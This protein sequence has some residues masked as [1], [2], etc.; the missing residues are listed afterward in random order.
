MSVKLGVADLEERMQR[1]VSVYTRLVEP[2]EN[3]AASFDMR[4]ANG[5]AMSGLENR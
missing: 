3:K 1:F 2:L 4:Y 5:F